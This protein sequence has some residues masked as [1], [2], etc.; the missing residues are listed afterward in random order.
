MHPVPTSWR[1]ADFRISFAKNKTHAYAYYSLAIKNVYGA[2]PLAA[3][4][5]E[6]HCKRDIYK[7]TMEYLQAFPVHFALIDAYLSADGPFGVFADPLP[8]PTRT[9]IGGA[10]LVAVDW[11]GA[12]KMGMSGRR[13]GLWDCGGTFHAPKTC[14]R[15]RAARATSTPRAIS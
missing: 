2:L 13:R 10:N 6:Y 3:K 15:L 12:T 4:F 5:K 14:G 7:T 9:I 8:N 11:V 1:D